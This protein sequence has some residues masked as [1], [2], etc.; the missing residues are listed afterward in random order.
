MTGSDNEHDFTDLAPDE[1][2]LQAARTDHD[3]V[4]A[5]ILSLVRKRLE[6]LASTNAG[7]DTLFR[8]PRDG[9]LW[10]L[11]FPEGSLFGG[12]PRRLSVISEADARQK[13]G[14]F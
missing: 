10:E 13:Y 3:A 14:S 12:G 7:W 8:D 5:R 6:R 4:D 9:R 2:V 11:T 1:V